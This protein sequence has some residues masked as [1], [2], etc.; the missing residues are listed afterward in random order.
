VAGAGT[1]PLLSHDVPDL[2]RAGSIA[3]VIARMEALLAPLAATDGV[4]SFTRL[5]L[6]VTRAVETELAGATFADPRFLRELD[7]VFA[8][9]FFGAVETYQRSARDAPRAWVPLFEARATR[10]IAPLQFALAGMNAHINRDL[11]VA[12]VTTWART[13][14]EPGVGSPQ[15]GDFERVNDVLARV[16]QRIKRE[17]LTGWLNVLDRLLHRFHRLDSILAMWNVRSARA[18]AWIN[19][20]AL[21][22]LRGDATLSDKY[23]RNLDRMVGL[24]S[25]GLLIPAD[26]SLRRADRQLGRLRRDPMWW[27]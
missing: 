12:L 25:R 17:Y 18:A 22:A 8:E 20:E 7:V 6:A 24:S 14:I 10:G 13:G 11:P 15:H 27:V 23:L 1:R 16:E 2:D 9:L 5:Y 21:F 3:G 4:A 19:G 26:T